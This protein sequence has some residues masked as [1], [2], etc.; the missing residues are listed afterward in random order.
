MFHPLVEVMR[1][2]VT[3]FFELSFRWSLRGIRR[4]R[5]LFRSV[6]WK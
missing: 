3:N 6:V 4:S 1:P 5:V 2:P